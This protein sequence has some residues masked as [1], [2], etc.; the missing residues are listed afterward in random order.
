MNFNHILF[1]K[2]I[3]LVKDLYDDQGQLEAIVESPIMFTTHHALSP[4]VPPDWKNHPKN[5]T[6]DY[7][8]ELPRILSYLIKRT[9]K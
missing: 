1:N 5:V 3:I 2:N 7:N 4:S 6:K 8:M 9:I